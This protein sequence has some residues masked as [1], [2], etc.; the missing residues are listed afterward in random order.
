MRLTLAILLPP[1]AGLVA[2]GVIWLAPYLT[3]AA[4][5]GKGLSLGSLFAAWAIPVY[6]LALV[7]G[8][9]V[10]AAALLAPRWAGIVTLAGMLGVYVLTFFLIGVAWVGVA[11]LLGGTAQWLALG[12]ATVVH[13]LAYLLLRP[14]RL[15]GRRTP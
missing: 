6:P 15:V 13:T 11:N 3:G 5:P 9:P 12:A 8:L 1:L 4:E 2:F 10:L 7:L 14:A